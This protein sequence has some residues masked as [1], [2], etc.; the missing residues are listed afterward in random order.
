[1]AARLLRVDTQKALQLAK[2]HCL[3]CVIQFLGRKT[4]L[5]MVK[6]Y[7]WPHLGKLEKV[8]AVEV[9]ESVGFTGLGFRA[10]FPEGA[11]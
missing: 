3:P 2:Y 8:L 9:R 7:E 5:Q 6:T 10:A 11:D 1:M 4:I